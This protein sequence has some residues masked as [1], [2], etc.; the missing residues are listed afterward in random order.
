MQ[1]TFVHSI[2]G[3][4]VERVHEIAERLRKARSDVKVVEVE[5]DAAKGMLAQHKLNF[6]PA[7]VIDGRVEYVG[8]PRWRFLLERID[9]VAAGIHS[10]RSSVQP[11]KA[12]AAKAVAPVRSPAAS[13]ASPPKPDAPEKPASAPSGGSA[14]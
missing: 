5:G 4:Q 12:A 14:A 10:P 11:E 8:I 6:G 13:P 1:V 2:Q 9:Q 3:H 7:I